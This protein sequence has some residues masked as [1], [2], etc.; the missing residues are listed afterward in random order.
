MLFRVPWKRF[1]R[2]LWHEIYEDDISNGAATLAYWLTLAVFPATIFV[3]ALLPYLP[4]ADID[5]AI[6]DLLYRALPEDAAK[7]FQ[8]VVEE[9]TGTQQG[10][11][12]SFGALGTLWAASAGMFAIMKQ[13]NITYDV[14]EGRSFLRARAISIGLSILF[15]V[16]VVGAF[17]LVVL[18]GLLE[19]W[20][21]SHYV[22]SPLL[23]GFFA[24]LRWALILFALLLGFALIYYLGPDVEQRF[25][26]ITPGSV[27]GVVLLI[28][29]SLG[30]R[31]YATNFGNYSATYGSIGAVIILMFWLYLAGLVILLGSEINALVEHYAPTGKQKGE[32]SERSEDAAEEAKAEGAIPPPP[33]PPPRGRR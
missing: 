19:S 5:R 10:G 30:F 6:M 8:G 28:L 26:F 21:G 4:I 13:L 7:M 11:L 25:I 15:A 29:A 33:P 23:L 1:F 3:M 20:V 18:G 9:V 31:F 12:L 24:W 16:L 17:S 14:H 32:K 22:A 27:L 2:E